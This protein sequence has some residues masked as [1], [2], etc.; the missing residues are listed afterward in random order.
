MSPQSL[1]TSSRLFD[2]FGTSWPM[3][4]I[5][6]PSKSFR[7]NGSCAAYKKIDNLCLNAARFVRLEERVFIGDNGIADH[8]R[9]VLGENHSAVKRWGTAGSAARNHS[10]ATAVPH[11]D[12]VSAAEFAREHRCIWVATKGWRRL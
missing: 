10:K 1:S 11:P 3:I 12:S 6:F 9:V 7:V 4:S 2:L 8:F 5:F